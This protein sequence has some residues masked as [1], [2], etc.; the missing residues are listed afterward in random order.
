M[1]DGSAPAGGRDGLYT[2]D[3]AA[4]PLWLDDAPPVPELT[5]EP[6]ATADVVVIGSGYTG[7]NA[8]LET[9]R[10]A[11]ATVLIGLS[12]QGGAFDET[13]VRAVWAH[14]GASSAMRSTPT[15]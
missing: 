14:T 13:I 4:R 7:L 12:G 10:G 1:A 8:A 15:L 11:R 6:P 9:A 5:A 2:A 3:A